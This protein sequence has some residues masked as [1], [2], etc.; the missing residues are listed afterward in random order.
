MYMAEREGQNDA[1]R[2]CTC[3]KSHFCCFLIRKS[4]IFDM[5]SGPFPC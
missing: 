5:L 4:L 3:G 1:A 2:V